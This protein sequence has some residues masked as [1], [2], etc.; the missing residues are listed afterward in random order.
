ML[1]REMFTLCAHQNLL[2]SATARVQAVILLQSLN[3]ASNQLLVMVF[4]DA[5]LFI[6]HTAVLGEHETLVSTGRSVPVF[7]ISN[8]NY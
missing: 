2:Y 1:M 5:V 4:S 3:R 6:T 8:N 7:V